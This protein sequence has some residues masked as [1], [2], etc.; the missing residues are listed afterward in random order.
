MPYMKRMLI[1][2]LGVFFFCAGPT[3]ET[4]AEILPNK[5]NHLLIKEAKAVRALHGFLLQCKLKRTAKNFRD[6]FISF[7][8]HCHE[9]ESA[10]NRIMEAL[11]PM[12]RPENIGSLC[13]FGAD[14]FAKLEVIEDI[15][16]AATKRYK[17]L[18]SLPSRNNIC[19][20]RFT[21]HTQLM[22]LGEKYE[23][24]KK[25]N[26]PTEREVRALAQMVM[27][28]VAPCWILPAGVK[29]VRTVRVGVLI[30]LHP[31]GTLSGP[32]KI[33]NQARMSRDVA[34]RAVAESALRA[35]RNPRCSPIRLPVKH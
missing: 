34:F 29:D 9:R 6:Q 4:Y 15:A 19:N 23:A 16:L 31:D 14:K 3:F 21:L 35:L 7:V 17:N 25:A 11:N 24:Y 12:G 8:Q 30:S 20:G 22:A 18:V 32:P 2:A 27:H 1:S 5:G 26:Q 33:E 28:Q 10:Q 13:D